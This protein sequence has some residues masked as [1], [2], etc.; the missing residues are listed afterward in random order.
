MSNENIEIRQR[1]IA[2]SRQ[3]IVKA[4]TRLLTSREAIGT[5]V[6]SIDLLR[7]HD[8]RVL[9]VTSGAVGMG[10]KALNLDRRPKELAQ[11][12]ALAAIGQCRLMAIYEEECRKYDIRTAQL[13]LTAAD[14]RSRERYL[15]VMNCINALWDNNVLPIVNENDSVSVAELKFGDNDSLAGM[16]GALTNSEL[17][18][19][20]TTEQGLRKSENG[21]LK[22]R[23]SVVGELG[24]E[25]LD[26]A[27]GTDNAELSVG[28]M[29][30]KLKAASIVTRAGEYLW[31]ADGRR[32]NIMESILNGE[33]VGTVFLPRKHKIPHRKRWISFFSKI[34]GTITVDDGAAKAIRDNGKSLLPSGI[35]ALDGSFKRGDT[36]EIADLNGIAFA[37]GLTNFDRNDCENIKG[38]HSDQVFA[39]LGDVDNVVVHRDNLIVL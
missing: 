18:I 32:A 12:Q 2:S 30:S 34:S 25:H 29:S 3:V 5:L 11:V 17:T 24:K 7:R 1:I 8:K 10:M 36:V 16:L 22:E 20:L 26:M 15:N 33:D 35:K 6:K 13:L 37:R 23:I 28:G 4:G 39:K 38:M 31:I 14:L 19:I 9:L 21:E 27:L